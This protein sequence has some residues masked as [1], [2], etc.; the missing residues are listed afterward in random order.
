M[1][2]YTYWSLVDNFEWAKGF[3]PKFGLY[4]V[5]YATQTRTATKGVAAYQAIIQ[6]GG[7]ITPDIR[8]QFGQ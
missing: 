8:A 7:K 3:A 4:H 2:G 1:W 6:A 5:D